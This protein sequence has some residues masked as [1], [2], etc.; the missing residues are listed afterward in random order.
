MKR[1][2][3]VI[4]VAVMLLTL[5]SGIVLA[6]TDYE[7]GGATKAAGGSFV[8]SDGQIEWL[9]PPA[10]YTLVEEITLRYMLASRVNVPAP[11]SNTVWV[12]QPFT[13]EMRQMWG[14]PLISLQKPATLVVRYKPEDLGG[15]S[16]ATLRLVVRYFDRWVEVAGTVDTASH[17]VTVHVPYGGDFGLIASDFAQ[18]VAAPAP[19][20]AASSPSPAMTVPMSSGVSGRVFYDKNGNGLFDAEDFPV[21]GA[22][23]RISSGG[24]SAL[25]RSGSDGSYSFWVLRESAYTVE[26]VVGPEWAFTTPSAVSDIRV[27]GLPGSVGRADFGMWYRLP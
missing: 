15:R 5:S 26:L 20:V 24:W 11:P 3:G 25:A 27:T 6:A 4:A 19:P 22:G 2:L 18:A 23:L 12:D 7:T 1:L 14:E 8:S 17:T 16:E 10:A 13:L 9:I 21:Q